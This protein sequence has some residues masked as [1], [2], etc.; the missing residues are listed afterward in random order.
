MKWPP[1]NPMNAFSINVHWPPAV[2]HNENTHTHTQIHFNMQAFF[3]HEVS[4]TSQNANILFGQSPQNV[5]SSSSKSSVSS[6]TTCCHDSGLD[7]R[8]LSARHQTGPPNC[9]YPLPSHSP[10][11]VCGSFL[12][13]KADSFAHLVNKRF[14]RTH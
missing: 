9:S 7:P 6:W 1:E 11:G 13:C 12:R 8:D 14:Q 10:R 3:L 2:F 4:K 5:A